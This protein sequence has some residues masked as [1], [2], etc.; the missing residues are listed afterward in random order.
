MTTPSN[1]IV[2]ISSLFGHGTGVIIGPHTVLTA[3]HVVENSQGQVINPIAFTDLIGLSI[4]VPGIASPITESMFQVRAFSSIVPPI[5][6]IGQVALDFAVINFDSDIF[7]GYTPFSLLGDSNYAGG[8]VDLAG[9]SASTND[10][11]LSVFN[12]TLAPDVFNGTLAPDATF[13]TLWDWNPP[14]GPEIEGTSGGPVYIDGTNELVGIG[15]TEGT[16][17]R[18]TPTASDIAIQD[19]AQSEDTPVIGGNESQQSFLGTT[20]DE[21]FTHL[22]IA[23][24]NSGS[25]LETVSIV[26]SSI[27]NGSLSD[28][29]GGSVNSGVYTVVGSASE[30]TAAIDGLVFAPTQNQAPS[31]GT[32]TTTFTI[33]DVD[34]GGFS[35][36]AEGTIIVMGE[37]AATSGTQTVTLMGT[38]TDPITHNTTTYSAGAQFLPIAIMFPAM[39]TDSPLPPSVPVT[40]SYVDE[41]PDP[42]GDNDILINQGSIAS[43]F[44]SVSSG[45]DL[46]PLNTTA[47][48]DVSLVSGAA[49]NTHGAGDYSEQILPLDL[50][51]EGGL[52]STTF[53]LDLAI[54]IYA[55]AIPE[56]LINGVQTFDINLGIVHLGQ[57][58]TTDVD[59]ENVATGDLTDVL[60]SNSGTL[61][62]FTAN[63]GID[64]VQA[65]SAE[66]VTVGITGEIA[67]PVLV[68]DSR[69]LF[70]L[71]SQDG[72]LPDEGVTL[73]NIP[74]I[75]AQVYN[76]ADPVLTDSFSDSDG[77]TLTQDG[78]NWTLSLGDV[79][80]NSFQNEFANIEIANAA[81][82]AFS[83]TLSGSTNISESVDGGFIQSLSS[84]TGQLA[85]GGDFLELGDFNPDSTDYGTHTETI[86]FD[87]LSVDSAGTTAL[88]GI[89]LTVTEN[90]A[91]PDI[92]GADL[93]VQGDTVIATVEAGHDAVLD[94]L[95]V[96]ATVNTLVIQ[97]PGEAEFDNTAFVS[98]LE[99][100]SGGDLLVPGTFLSIDPITIDAGGIMS[101]FG[102]IAGN[103]SVNG[104]LAANGGALDINDDVTG[105]GTLTFNPGAALELES[106]I[107]ATEN[108]QFN[109]PNEILILGA[110]AEIMAPINGMAPGDLIGLDGQQVAS[111]IYDTADDVLTIMGSGGGA[112][113][114][115]FVGSYQQSDFFL[116]NGDVG[117]TCFL[118]GSRI[119]TQCGDGQ[120]ETLAIGDLVQTKF[121]GLA[122][123]KWIGYRLI[124]CSRHPDPRKVWPVRV[125]ADALGEGLPRR[126][127][128]L[129][130]DHAVY[131]DDVLIPIK[132][133]INGMTIE[134]VPMDDVAYYHIE[135][136]QHDVLFA[137]GLPT[138][139]YLD[140]GDRS[141]FSNGDKPVTLHPDF[142]ALIWDAMGCAPL[143]VTGSA[144][145]AVRTRLL[146]RAA[147]LAVETDRQ[148][149]AG[150][151]SRAA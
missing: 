37:T 111:A 47:T 20:D 83:D 17:I 27:A 9:Y 3:A 18:L 25:Q 138:E 137:E 79:T 81:P 60:S 135:L 54:K 141:K 55:P 84:L 148:K 40:V 100:A 123:V 145:A 78:S 66:A 150:Q 96:D 6:S 68:T 102:L 88:S 134:Q 133:L 58:A 22:T 103:M 15:S 57:T 89:T 59:I 95:L 130:P 149:S 56:F 136:D 35:S 36:T 147:M 45:V 142:S 12:G 126:D 11:A 129:S 52:D 5:T 38:I 114:L 94:P 64:S 67:G 97:G 63:N 1:S 85:P 61:G 98:I 19:I 143:V 106:T 16:A 151:N 99:I 73:Q 4:T 119:G 10:G 43:P 50:S 120:I 107:A 23:D 87:P 109:A 70:D 75:S 122:P 8:P 139:S 76:Y 48:L 44:F 46:S 41:N 53:D 71:V 108:V 117:V 77:A 118:S 104:T 7:N 62:Q 13:T 115:N 93:V 72:D 31:G 33:T 49:G 30:V 105:A 69:P 82:P 101:G 2:L 125:R 128:W 140:A 26:L 74:A 112:Y 116:T 21:P 127:L 14:F 91:L 146:Q 32:T 86:V 80:L 131:A 124:D 65:G 34:S 39:R 29:V 51:Y 110:S 90:V 121:S 42:H 28:P 132:H 113:S 144:L 92:L 24:F